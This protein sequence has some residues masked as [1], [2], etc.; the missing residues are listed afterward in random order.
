[1]GYETWALALAYS[2][3]SAFQAIMLFMLISKKLNGGKLLSFTPIL[4]TII[5]SFLT[6]TVMFFILKFFD[7]AVWVKRL[8]FFID[9]NAVQNLNFENFVIDTRYTANLLVL[10]LATSLIGA[11]VYLLSS[12]LLRSNELAAI[13][14][15][16]KTR[17]FA[18]LPKKETESLIPSASD[19]DKG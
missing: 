13:F 18:A 4:K 12:A 17:S 1:M 15:I 14:K 8:S 11:I 5:S 10:T 19:T 2:L 9:I 7:R 3:G 6:G 16:I